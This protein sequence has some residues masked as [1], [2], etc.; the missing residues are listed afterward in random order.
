MILRTRS[1]HF[2]EREAP[3][4]SPVLKWSSA[5]SSWTLRNSRSIV[6]QGATLRHGALSGL[7]LPLLWQR[8]ATGTQSRGPDR[9]G[10]GPPDCSS[11][12]DCPR[13]SSR[14]DPSGDSGKSRIRLI[15]DRFTR[16]GPRDPRGPRRPAR[17]LPYDPRKVSLAHRLV[18]GGRARPLAEVACSSGKSAL[19][20]SG[21]FTPAQ[22]DP[23]N[24]VLVAFPC[25]S[26][27]HG[28]TW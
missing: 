13:T 27:S 15:S 9:A 16:T 11:A 26:R 8:K 5:D 23:L 20:Q 2:T 7:P 14:G 1:C 24:C 3:T 17:V 22:S 28:R 18:V 25:Q 6:A 10:A 21:G 19:E 4:A 12:V